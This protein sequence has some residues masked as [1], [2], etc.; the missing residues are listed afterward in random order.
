MSTSGIRNLEIQK[1]W[2]IFVTCKFEIFSLRKLSGHLWKEFLTSDIHTFD[3]G[4][5]DS[6]LSGYAMKP[7]TETKDLSSGSWK[8]MN[9]QLS[10]RTKIM[11][12]MKKK[13]ELFKNQPNSQTICSNCHKRDNKNGTSPVKIILRSIK[14]IVMIPCLLGSSFRSSKILQDLCQ[15]LKSLQRSCP[16]NRIPQDIG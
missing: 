8:E 3:S 2:I 10:M 15:S 13:T 16:C 1:F 11:Q 7:S 9:K 12:W 14:I 6:L 4:K 5:G